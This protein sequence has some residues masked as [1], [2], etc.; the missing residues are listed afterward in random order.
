MKVE[1]KNP[2]LAESLDQGFRHLRA[3]KFSTVVDI[4]NEAKEKFPHDAG[5]A[6]LEGGLGMETGD[7]RAAVISFHKALKI[8]PDDAGSWANLSKAYSLLGYRKNA[9]AANHNAMQTPHKS[10]DMHSVLGDSFSL[11][12]RHE[13]A[14]DW[15]KSAYAQD[16]KNSAFGINL[17]N[18]LSFVGQNS[19]ALKVIDQ[20]IA[21]DPNNGQAHW[22][23]SRLQKSTTLKSPLALVELGR[24]NANDYD[25]PFFYY[26]AG[27]G[28]EDIGDWRRAFEYY[29]LGAAAKK[30]FVKY[31]EA[32]EV[33]FTSSLTNRISTKWSS[34]EPGFR[35]DL[36]PVFIVGQ[37]RSGTTLVERI[38]SSHPE[39]AGL[40]EVQQFHIAL[41]RLA[42]IKLAQSPDKSLVNKYI[43]VSPRAVGET[44]IDAV[45]TLVGETGVFTD[46]TLT[47]F[48]YLPFIARALPEAR[49]IWVSRNPMATCWSNFKQLFGEIAPHSY[50]LGEMARHFARYQALMLH[51]KE[52]FPDRICEVAY[53]EVVSS[54]ALA[55]KKVC[56]FIG[57]SWSKDMLNFHRHKASV[58]TASAVQVRQP[59]YDDSIRQWEQYR[60]QLGVPA[61]ILK[62]AG[63]E[64]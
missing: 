27:K 32:H 63:I 33:E 20:T 11:L 45:Q 12:E 13:E 8:Q 23:R 28:F 15:Y 36:T 31:D 58:S 22:L 37:P 25:K 56:R 4:L 61:S 30:V 9:E 18:T 5:V 44:Y 3:G 1:E 34:S 2:A 50:D 59:I 48:L 26:A 57:V 16:P 35:T 38:L 10:N 53:E 39:V 52:L 62:A 42:G 51:W 40:G 14:L 46:K 17:C 6:R 19:E 29:S 24:N 21:C 47:N 54:P 49:F 7:L 43:E 60:D 64:F 41:R 55:S